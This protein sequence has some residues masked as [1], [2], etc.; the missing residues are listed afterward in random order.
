MDTN[1]KDHYCDY[2][3]EKLGDHVDTNPKDHVCDYCNEK[4]SECTD[5]NKDHYCDYCGEKLS[6]CF[7]AKP[8]DHYC[9]YCG[10][11]LSDH[12]DTNPKDHICDYCSAELSECA[13]SNDDGKCDYCDEYLKQPILGAPALKL[14]ALAFGY[15]VGTIKGV[16]G[17]ILYL[18]LNRN[19][20][21]VDE[22]EDLMAATF[23]KYDADGKAA[24]VVKDKDGNTLNRNSDK[25]MTTAKITVTAQNPIGIATAEYTIVV[26][27]D[28]NCNGRIENNDATKITLHYINEG[29]SNDNVL[30]GLIL[31]AADTN[32]NGR[33]ENNDI[34]LNATKYVTP[35]KYTSQLKSEEEE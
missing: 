11:K 27:G 2:C 18:D 35:V 17:E 24:I 13:D 1:P 12:V 34:V 29:K 31:E 14:G 22:L 10:E 5:N 19:G 23:V 26:L 7:D 30:T 6:D 16:A 8:K 9:D 28:V 21:T 20:V 25:V 4:L 32:R 15:E 33:I 3:G